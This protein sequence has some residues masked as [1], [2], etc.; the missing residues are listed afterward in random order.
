MHKD[1]LYYHDTNNRHVNLGQTV[2][3]NEAGYIKYQLN[4]SRFVMELYAKV[5]YAYWK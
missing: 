1:R 3:E 4:N 5:G 2:I